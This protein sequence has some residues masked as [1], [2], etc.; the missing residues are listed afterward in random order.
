MISPLSIDTLEPLKLDVRFTSDPFIGHA[1]GA[2]NPARN[3]L[4]AFGA[5]VFNI[6]LIGNWQYTF[7][8]T[9]V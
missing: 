8:F 5:L 6:T 1:R 9:N 7:L 3:K 4:F 2:S